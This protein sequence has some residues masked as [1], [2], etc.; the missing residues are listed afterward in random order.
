MTS[1]NSVSPTKGV[2]APPFSADGSVRG[3]LLRQSLK[4]TL[5]AWIPGAFWQGATSSTAMTPFG[6]YLHANDFIFALL[7][8]APQLSSLLM[9]PAALVLQRLGTRK[10]FF[11]WTVPPPRPLFVLI[12]LLHRHDPLRP[13]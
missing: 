9:I 8:A 2:P 7:T 3:D 6:Q 10:P 11:I 12:G 4:Y 1:L 13:I 5:L